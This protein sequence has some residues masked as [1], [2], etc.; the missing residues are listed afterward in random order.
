[1]QDYVT[2]ANLALGLIGEDDAI[3]SPDES[4]KAARE[5]KNA[6]D[7][8]RRF[9]LAEANWSFGLRTAEL[10]ARPATAEHPILL[11]ASAFPLPPDMLKFVELV[12]EA[13]DED[14]SIEAGPDSEEIL[15]NSNGP[16]FVRYIRDVDSPER[17]SPAFVEAFTARLGWQICDAMSGSQ[18]RKTSAGKAYAVAIAKA[19]KDNN[20]RKTRRV[21]AATPFTEGR[22]SLFPGAPN[23]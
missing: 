19:K 13:L 17:W 7:M 20:R 14:Y 11:Y 12:D 15:V 3:T 21:H 4:S 9:V 23:T 1:V 2:I 22:S 10:T 6:W 16:L 18:S 5:I 8:V